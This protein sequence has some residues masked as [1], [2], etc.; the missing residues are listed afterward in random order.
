MQGLAP[1][2][3]VVIGEA[4]LRAVRDLFEV[5]ALPP[6]MVKGKS[7]P[8][9]VWRV[10][11][12]RAEPAPEVAAARFVGRDRELAALEGAFSRAVERSSVELVTVVGEPG[13]GKTRLIR[14][15]RNRLG[16]TCRWL[17][18][19]CLPYGEAVTFAP[20]ADTVRQMAEIWPADD[21]AEAAAKLGALAALI[22][23]DPTERQWLVSRLEP[24][25]GVRAGDAEATIP[26]DE[27]ALAWSRVVGAAAV[28]GP[29]VVELDDLHWA[30]PELLEILERLAGALADRPVL[31]LFTARLE[32]L[33]RT[34]RP[35]LFVP[36]RPSE[37]VGEGA[38]PAGATT[39]ELARLS[40]R[41]SSQL[42]SGLLAQLVL[43]TP[44]RE[45]LLERAGG[46]PLYALEFARMLAEQAPSSAG[47][48]LSMPESV[49]AVIAARLDGISTDLRSLVLDA[50]VVGTSFWP[51][52]L[53]AVGSRTEDQVRS[54]V[55]AL[56]HRGLVQARPSRI[57]GEPEFGFTHA[58]IREVAYGR[59]PRA[60]RARR[61]LASGSWIERAS[62]D[63]AEERAEMLARH[64][65]SAVELAEAAGERDVAEQARGPAVRWLM[66]AGDRAAR[67]DAVSAFALFD[68]AVRITPP[69]TPE[70][71]EALSQSARMGRRSGQIDGREVLGRLE[72]ALAIRRQLGDPVAIGGALVRLGSQAGAVGE[73]ARSRELLAEAVQI[74]EAQPLGPEL[75]R[76]YA[77]WAEEE[78]FAGDVRES[79]EYAGRALAHLEPGEHDDVEIMSLHIRGD[80]RCS[81]GDLGGLE[82]LEE[83]LRLSEASGSV[84]D[85]V[86]SEN[87]LAEWLGVTD[88]PKAALRHHEAAV[89]TAERRGVVSQGLWAKGSMIG[90]LFES[91]DWDHAQ[92]LAGELLALGPE[93]LDR[94]LVVM[95]RAMKSRIALLRGRLEDADPPEELARLARS[96]DELHALTPALAVVAEL[97]AAAGLRTE[98]AG[99]VKEFLSATAGVAAE[100]R[101][102]FLAPLARVCVRVGEIAMAEE[103][104]GPA[105]RAIR[106]DQL[107]ELSARATVAEAKGDVGQARDGYLEAAGGWRAFG[108]PLEEAEALLGYARCLVAMGRREEA[109]P[110]EGR[111]RGILDRLGVH[112]P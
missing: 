46:N 59:I 58:L 91:G 63:R 79:K 23:A 32:L 3:S 35:A 94:A 41:E 85:I 55:E 67:L 87:Y 101:N 81:L 66:T 39:I 72:A 108:D 15:F 47:G 7:E 69:G 44:A 76:A 21:P 5:E 17:V 36:K 71:A 96:I 60:Q 90:S 56:V 86:T 43:P 82:D 22:E 78:M 31:L 4:T 33:E 38:Y 73:S 68:R 64:F 75:A 107:S 112:P 52:A 103:I 12:E 11:G 62:G 37:Q 16:A 54:G 49:Q 24:V 95:A 57:E 42:L 111:A 74:L 29:A 106:R 109:V 65:G 10:A 8:L 89:A 92:Q 26:A 97:A 93:R 100:Y 53:E 77:Y 25:A 40:D 20:I 70:H 6:A 51:G 1:R 102:A 14:E 84:A 18:G 2:N 104:A 13:I 61:H 83:A 50:S 9:A 45:E 48:P 28:G 34:D 105:D 80:A 19:R 88:G 27:I 30:E 98:A 99:Y 110:V